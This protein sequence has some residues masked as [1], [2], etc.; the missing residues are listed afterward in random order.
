MYRELFDTQFN[1]V[2]G[3]EG[4][5]VGMGALDIQ[6]L[7][8]S[9]NVRHLTGA[10]ISDV[11]ML[12]RSNRRFYRQLGIRPSRS[13]LTE[14]VTN[15]AKGGDYAGNVEGGE[16]G[17]VRPEDA[18]TYFVGF[19]DD[20]DELVA[21]LDLIC[22]YP[23]LHDAFIGWFMVDAD[24]QGRGV[25]SGIFADVRA[26]MKAQGYTRLQLKCPKASESALSFWEEQGF[27]PVGHEESN[28]I[29]DVIV[30]ARDI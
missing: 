14:I 30:L 6:A 11:V 24:L 22:G 16:G 27:Q 18:A 7:G 28:G 10:D 2:L 5:A 25:G 23:E 15:I 17:A 12:V 29:Y 4:E 9:Y 13:R 19:F 3:R 21:V 8:T 1:Q 26:A 20:D